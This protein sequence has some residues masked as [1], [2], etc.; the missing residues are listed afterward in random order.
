[1]SLIRSTHERHRRT[2]IIVTHDY[3]SLIQIADRIILLD[4][5]TCD[6]RDI[7][8]PQWD[9]IAG[10][11]LSPPSFETEASLRTVRSAA[12]EF[13]DGVFTETGRFVE[14][15]VLLPSTIIPLWRSLKWGLRYSGY[16]L[17]LVAGPSAVMYLAIAGMIL[18]YV[19][20]D[21]IFRY[22]PFR[23]F[24]EPLLTENL[25]H[26]TGFSLFRFLVPILATILVAARS[27]AAVASD[28]GS[29]V[30]GN[31]L[32]AMRTMG[33]NPSR[34]LKTP[35]LYA[36]L[37]GTPLLTFFSYLVA[38]ATAAVAFLMTHG[39]LG[40]AFWDGH[41]HHE[42][43]EPG[44]WFYRGAGWWFAKLLCCGV[45]IAL[46]SWQHGSCRKL[47]GSEISQGVTRTILWSTLYVLFIHFLFSL[48]EFTPKA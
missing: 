6:L 25:L 8:R 13:S 46:I 37:I 22:L 38:A 36:F 4:H 14:E 45:G 2:S 26:G 5:Q 17:R 44:S 33:M 12:R 47:S 42:L 27:G 23:Q 43:R 1:A 48:Y 19:S 9:A 28:V 16:Y 11:L 3:H 24:T 32:D 30:Y 18:G 10:L 35:I 7:P 41:F 34:I 39:H 31:Q 21:F 40:I 29:K 20:Q 15:L